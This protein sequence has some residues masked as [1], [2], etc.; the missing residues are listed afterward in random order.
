[1][2]IH[3]NPR[4]TGIGSGMTRAMTRMKTRDGTRS[5]KGVSN[6]RREVWW[7]ASERRRERAS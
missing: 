7:K 4:L 5:G 3:N 6:Q 1:M 2:Y